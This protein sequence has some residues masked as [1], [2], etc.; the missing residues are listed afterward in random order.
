MCKWIW[1]F[2]PVDLICERNLV[3]FFVFFEYSFLIFFPPKYF[4]END[5]EKGKPQAIAW[6]KSVTLV[7]HER[8]CHFS[9]DGNRTRV[10]LWRHTLFWM[11]PFD[12]W[13]L[14]RS[15]SVFWMHLKNSKCP[16]L[17]MYKGYQNNFTI[18]CY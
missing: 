18:F 12:R 3:N 14:T 7:N 1:T 15:P 6:R 10:T 5:S 17:E 9:I 4:F 16:Y 11:G 8:F 13:S 2:S